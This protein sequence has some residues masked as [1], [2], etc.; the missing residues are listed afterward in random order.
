MGQPLKSKTYYRPVK[1]VLGRDEMGALIA[2]MSVLYEDLRI[3]FNA[4]K[5]PDK[6]NLDV[7]QPMYRKYYFLRRST[8]TLVEF[9]GSFQTL[10]QRPE[11]KT[12]KK[13]FDGTATAR[14]EAAREYFTANKKLLKDNRNAYGGH[15]QLSTSRKVLDDMDPD[16]PGSVEIAFDRATATAGPRLHFASEL[17]ALAFLMHKP[18][19]EELE[20]FVRRLF[21]TIREGWTHC[22][23]T[24]HTLSVYFI[25]PRF[26]G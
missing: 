2:R 18:A 4:S 1:S 20:S 8:V 21:E 11:F 10:D 19:S 15:F 3:E 26:R 6:N 5:L 9:M 14:W 25:V 23:D 17:V 12:V 22:T 16:T 13:P 7:L 24:M